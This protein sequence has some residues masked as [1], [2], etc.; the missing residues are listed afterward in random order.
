MSQCKSCGASIEWA[1][2]KKGKRSPVNLD[3][4]PHWSTC[5]DAKIWKNKEQNNGFYHTN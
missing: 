5:P 3:G 4:V 2:T 1:I